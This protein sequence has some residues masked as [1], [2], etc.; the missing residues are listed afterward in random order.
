MWCG[1]VRLGLLRRGLA[2]SSTGRKSSKGKNNAKAPEAEITQLRNIGIMAHIDAGK[3]TTTERMLFYAGYSPNLG[4]V[5]DGDTI[6]DY[7]AQER[8]RGI[9]IQSAAISFSW[10]GSHINLIDTPGHVD[11]TMEVERSLRVL[12]GAVALFDG[13]AGVEAQSET[14]WKQSDRYNV[15]RIAFVNKLDR[16]GA[17]YHRT[18]EAITQR[19][20]TTPLKIQLPLYSND[21][22]AAIVDLISMEVVDWAGPDGREV[23]RRPLATAAQEYTAHSTPD[24]VA[25]EALQARISLV[26]IY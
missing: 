6:M 1:T 17:S 12:D 13:V 3:T 10:G 2:S 20:R 26:C 4:E 19:L 25:D 14:V 7:M 5:H 15:P 24:N 16:E 22:F 8:E 18:A 21:Q 9:T 23:R 11:F